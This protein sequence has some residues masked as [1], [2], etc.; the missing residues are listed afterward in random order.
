V[1]LPFSLAVR[2]YATHQ[3]PG[4]TPVLD[5]LKDNLPGRLD[6]FV[7]G[8]AL[9]VWFATKQ[10]KTSLVRTLAAPGVAFVLLTFAANVWDNAYHGSIAYPWV[11]LTNDVELAAFA[12][13][14]AAFLTCPARWLALPFTAPPVQLLGMMSYSIY[15]WHT[16]GGHNPDYGVEDAWVYLGVC[17]TLAAVT[18]RF[19]EFPEKSF[20]KLF[21]TYPRLDPSALSAPV[22]SAQ[23]APSSD[24]NP[25]AA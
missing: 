19:V 16:I 24:P 9:A 14:T 1:T 8:M 7:A 18:Y 5:A 20:R 25:G 15:V 11:A 6:D 12:F 22:P 3:V 4:G 21:L 2:Y 17:F 13:L 23:P 10:P